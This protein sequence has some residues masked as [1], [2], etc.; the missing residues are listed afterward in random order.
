MTMGERALLD[1][2]W[3]GTALEG[4]E[5]GDLHVVAEFTRGALVGVIDGLGHGTE[6]ACAARAAAR[7]LEAFAGEPLAA[8]L[9]R[10]HEALHGTRG[11]VMSLASFDAAGSRMTWAGV[12]NVEGILLRA[13]AQAGRRHE[14]LTLRGGIVGYRL[15]RPHECTI[16]V[17]HGDTLILATDGIHAGF[18]EIAS[19]TDTPRETAESILARYSRGSDD[20]LVLVA[21]YLGAALQP[22]LQRGEGTSRALER[23]WIRVTLREEADVP[24]ARIR[25]QDLALAEGFPESR[26]AAIATAVSEVAWNIVLHAGAGE[27]ALGVADERGRRGIVVVARDE[28]PGIR[29]V[30]GA[31]ED[32]RSTARGL[33]LGL[34]SA[35]RLMDEFALVS[36]VGAGTT[37]TM[38]KWAHA[39]E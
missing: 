5:S 34:P 30:A 29:D 39:V 8:L 38:K 25:A 16:P 6:A 7:V 1:S 24:L 27:I 23:G 26:A 9:E 22:S 10:C 37:I 14:A 12:G 19:A 17:F 4:D 28:A 20:A 11:A 32:G 31:M 33:G 21:R 3:A 36:E 15:P 35:R 18:G 13:S 2:A